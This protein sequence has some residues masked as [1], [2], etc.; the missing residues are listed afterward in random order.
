MSVPSGFKTPGEATSTRFY[1]NAF[2][3]REHLELHGQISMD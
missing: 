2:V 3:G 1:S